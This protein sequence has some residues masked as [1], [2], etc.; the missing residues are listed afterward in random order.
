M[1]EERDALLSASLDG[2]LDRRQTRRLRELEASDPGL[3]A[4]R[5][6]LAYADASL[7][8][9]LARALEE[10]VPLEATEAIIR[11]AEPGRRLRRLGVPVLAAALGA[12]ASW[13]VLTRLDGGAAPAEALPWVEEVAVHHRLHAAEDR[14]RAAVPAEEADE[15]ESWLGERVGRSFEVPDLT[16]LGLRFEGARLLPAGGEPVAQL[17]YEGPRDAFVALSLTPR[18]G[19]E[20]APFEERDL[21]DLQAVTWREGGTAFALMGPTGGPSLLPLARLVQT[22]I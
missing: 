16:P 7:R 19:A 13:G 18:P 5:D 22:R 15:I 8:R 9:A 10:P 4:R 20:D 2:A 14:H 6:E 12:A 17:V 3:V 11:A 21:D 1:S